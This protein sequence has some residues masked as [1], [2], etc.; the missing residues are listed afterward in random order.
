METHSA[1]MAEQILRMTLKD[2]AR[3]FK[4]LGKSVLRKFTRPSSIWL[5]RTSALMAAARSSRESMDLAEALIIEFEAPYVEALN[6][7]FEALRSQPV[8]LG[9]PDFKV[10][11]RWPKYE[12][13]AY[14]ARVAQ[15]RAEAM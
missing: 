11:R 4:P 9:P 2:R 8:K 14:L 6:D 15:H 1:E 12:K 7:Y 3:G 5:R 13:T 10:Y